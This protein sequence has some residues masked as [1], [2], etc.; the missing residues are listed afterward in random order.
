MQAATLHMTVKQMVMR[1]R[2]ENGRAEE[3]LDSTVTGE[4]VALPIWIR[5]AG[6]GGKFPNDTLLNL[7]KSGSDIWLSVTE[8]RRT[9]LDFRLACTR[10][11]DFEWLACG[12]IPEASILHIMSFDGHDLHQ[13]PPKTIVSSLKSPYD[14]VFSSATQMWNLDTRNAMFDRAQ[15]NLIGL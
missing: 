6:K 9:N 15:H 4:L 7:R 2:K 10:S 8:L 13:Q 11:H 14:C 3:D 5:R 12:H 1:F